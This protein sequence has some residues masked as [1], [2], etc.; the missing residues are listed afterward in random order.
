[1]KC[2]KMLFF[3]I[4]VKL[5]TTKLFVELL[6]VWSLISLVCFCVFVSNFSFLDIPCAEKESAVN[7]WLTVSLKA[8]V[9]RSIMLANFCGRGLVSW[10]KRGSDITGLSCKQ[11]VDQPQLGI[12]GSWAIFSSRITCSTWTIKSDDFSDRQIRPIFAWQTTDF[13]WPILLADE[14]GQLYRSSTS[15]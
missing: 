15:A 11:T 8:R 14:I 4:K 7:S 6:G 5:I 3:S 10:E 9:R 12:L 13:C 2:S 1:M